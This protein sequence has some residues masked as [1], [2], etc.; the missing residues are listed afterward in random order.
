MEVITSSASDFIESNI[1]ISFR[2]NALSLGAIDRGMT[3]KWCRDYH[4]SRWEFDLI[5]SSG[6]HLWISIFD[7]NKVFVIPQDLSWKILWS[8]AKR[9]ECVAPCAHFVL[10][11]FTSFISSLISS[12]FPSHIHR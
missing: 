9:S 12:L 3:R 7:T 6:S 11:T 4:G 8:H 10:D 5:K 1:T 2:L